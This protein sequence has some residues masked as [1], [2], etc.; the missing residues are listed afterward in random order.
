MLT[1]SQK[2]AVF[3]HKK[4]FPDSSLPRCRIIHSPENPSPNIRTTR[5]DM[6]TNPAPRTAPA[7][8]FVRLPDPPEPEDMNNNIFLHLPGNSHNLVEHFGNEDTT[9][10]MGDAYISREPTSSRQGLFH[11]D[12]LI[13]FNVYP[14]AST[15]RNGYII[16]EQ[17]KPPD[18]VMEIASPT[19]GH[20][21][22]TD[23][24][25]GYASLGIPEYWRFDDSGGQHHGAPLAGDHLV[26]GVYQPIPIERIDDQT[27]QGYSTVLDLRL[28]WEDGMLGWY[29]PATGRHII[30]FRDERDRANAEREARQEAEAQVDAEREARIQAE[31][32]AENAEARARELESELRHRQ[33]S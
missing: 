28:R 26:D 7:T 17:G 19:T 9:I 18:F 25:E 5:S 22:V 12:L 4:N 27:H 20:R 23:K 1:A 2:H 14:A 29:D 16:E 3:P 33:Q 24:R 15:D 31:A 6:T 13:A 32:R 8:D 11:P 30:R 10:I 21:D